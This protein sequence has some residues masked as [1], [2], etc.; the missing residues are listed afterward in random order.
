MNSNPKFSYSILSEIVFYSSYSRTIPKNRREGLSMNSNSNI[1]YSYNHRL[2]LVRAELGVY[3][4]KA[5][6]FEGRPF[7]HRLPLLK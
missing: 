1:F 7:H 3:L 4:D 5:G 6:Y 2:S